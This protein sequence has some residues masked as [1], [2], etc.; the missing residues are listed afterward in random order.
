[1]NERI[2]ELR[3]H[4]GLTQQAFAEKIEVKRNTIATYEMG[5]NEPMDPIV[6]AICREFHVNETWLRTGEGQMFVEPTVNEQITAWIDQI[7][8]EEPESCKVRLVSALSRLE[9]EGWKALYELAASFVGEAPPDLIP[10]EGQEG[11]PEEDQGGEEDPYA[12]MDEEEARLQKEADMVR[13]SYL[14]THRGA[15]KSSG[16]SGGNGNTG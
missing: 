13:E 16:S 7:L 4:L 11:P 2:K 10:S 12:G 14:L 15:G 3:K 9:P 8:T 5:R 6:K 1:M